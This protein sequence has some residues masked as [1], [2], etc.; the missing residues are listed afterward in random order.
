MHLFGLIGNPLS[1]SFSKKYFAEK[2]EKERLLDFHYEN[3]QLESINELEK[4]LRLPGLQGL[5]V[6][7]PY[8]EKVLSFLDESSN[9]VKQIGACNCIK[10]KNGKLIGYN[11]DA[12]AFKNSLF[13]KLNFSLNLHAL[14][15]GTGGASKAV[16]FVLEE[17]KINF[18]LVSRNPSVNQLSYTQLDENVM[19][20]FKLIINTTPLGMFPIQS[21]MP[22]IPYELLN[23]DNFLFDLIANPAQTEF[24]KRGKEKG[25][26]IQN[27][28]DMF[29]IQAEES[30]K[31]WNKD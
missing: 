4:V 13:K 28:L 14:V 22:L 25:A 23:S 11:T 29:Q 31:I 30:W 8:K 7:I 26:T 24:L 27:G 20:I 6:T 3:F 16:Q 5:N 15:L 19:Q 12:I 21:E 1:H 10:I 17:L 2:F 9:E 18:Q